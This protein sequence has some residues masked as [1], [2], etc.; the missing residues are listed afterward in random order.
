[1]VDAEIVIIVKLL[2]QLKYFYIYYNFCSW[3]EWTY[4]IILAQTNK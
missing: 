4:I 3:G 1:M 2:L